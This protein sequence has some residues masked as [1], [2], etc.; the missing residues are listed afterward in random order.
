[1]H[2]NAFLE[3]SDIETAQKLSDRINTEGLHKV[4]DVLARRY[5][6]AADSP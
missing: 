5:C 2:D 4:L 1:M 6:P 3:I